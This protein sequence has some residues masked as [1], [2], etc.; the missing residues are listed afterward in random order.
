MK[1]NILKKLL[2]LFLI[3]GLNAIS[4]INSVNASDINSA[5]IHSIGDCGELLTYKGI[6]VKANYV[7]YIKDGAHYP[8]YCMDKT[9]VG[10]DTN[11]YTVSVQDSIKDVGLWRMIINGYPYKSIQELGV[12][13]K[14]EAFTATKQ[15]IYC[16]IHGNK[17]SDYAAIGVAGQR[18]LNAMSKIISSAQNSTENKISSTIKI[19]K[20][21]AEW[22]QDSI[23]KNY[24]SKT[25]EVTAGANI[26]NYK[27]TLTK[28]NGGDLGGIKLTDEK[29][30]EKTEFSPNEKFKILIPL[31]NMKEAGKIALK[32]EA[33][34][35]T[36][37]ILYGTAPNAGLQDYALTYATY[38]DGTGNI[39]DEYFKNE[40]KITIIKQDEKTKDKLEGVEFELLDENKNIAYQGLKTNKEG[41][42]E[43][44][45]IVPGTYYLRETNPIDGYLSYDELIKID[46]SLNQQLTITVNNNKEDKP[47][48][49]TS[50]KELEVT[51]E[52]IKTNKEKEIKTEKE[53]VTQTKKLPVTGM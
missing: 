14:A 37:P 43:I 44:T 3:L 16:Y 28:E 36:K 11:G 2:V 20:N 29:N 47:I 23:E 8:A 52:V 6:V 18:T 33:K 22:K 4:F 24:L 32:V 34:I 5:Y 10:A 40:T 15:A 31:K 42:I 53:S 19:N 13:N 48:I 17:L 26:K 49:E 27:I 1:K 25:Y 21:F 7:E 51:Q 35:E 9:K 50:K 46:I 38:E 45:D 30:K 41:K 12:A 39:Q